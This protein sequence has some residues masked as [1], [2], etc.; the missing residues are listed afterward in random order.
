M[1]GERGM[2]EL[3]F[4]LLSAFIFVVGGFHVFASEKSKQKGLLITQHIQKL[5]KLPNDLSKKEEELLLKTQR[6]RL[7]DPLQTVHEQDHFVENVLHV[8][9]ASEIDIPEE[10]IEPKN[11]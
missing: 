11:K 2:M 10:T 6:K 5:P 3:Y 9:H 4:L 7:W 8:L 1:L